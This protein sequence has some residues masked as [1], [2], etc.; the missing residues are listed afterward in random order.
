MKNLRVVQALL[1]ISMLSLALGCK[2][3]DDNE[4]I[5]NWKRDLYRA[6]VTK[7]GPAGLS[8]N[9]RPGNAIFLS[10][11][12]VRLTESQKN[13]QQDSIFYGSDRLLTYKYEKVE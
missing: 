8:K 3:N 5:Y 11:D 12:F 7:E 4:V 1:Y 13:N 6:M 10:S 2:K 9:L